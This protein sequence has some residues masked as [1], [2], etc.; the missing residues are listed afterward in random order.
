M[1]RQRQAQARAL[2]KAQKN[3]Q[4]P[5]YSGLSIVGYLLLLQVADRPRKACSA[6]REAG[7]QETR[8]PLLHNHNLVY[9]VTNGSTDPEDWQVRATGHGQELVRKAKALGIYDIQEPAR[10]PKS[11][12]RKRPRNPRRNPAGISHRY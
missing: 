5:I 11:K 12:H 4:L 3:G 2:I 10:K 1:H 7:V 8:F 9:T 6:M